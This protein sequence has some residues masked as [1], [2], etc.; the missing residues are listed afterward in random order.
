M[1]FV[2]RSPSETTS[3][4]NVVFLLKGLLIE[5][6]SSYEQ[7]TDNKKERICISPKRMFS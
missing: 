2:C 7:E 4:D 5:V 1:H 6:F 3:F